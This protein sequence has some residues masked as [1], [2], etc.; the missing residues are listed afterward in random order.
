MK[1]NFKE[2]RSKSIVEFAENFKE[3]YYET[4]QQWSA[5]FG[6]ENIKIAVYE[7]DQLKDR[8]LFSDFFSILGLE[9]S[10]DYVL[11][12]KEYANLGLNKEAYLILKACPG[13]DFQMIE[14]LGIYPYKTVTSSLDLLSAS[15]KIKIIN[16]YQQINQKIA[17]EF[18][19]RKNGVLFLEPLPDNENNN[20]TLSSD[21]LIKSLIEI[22]LSKNDRIAEITNRERSL[23]TQFIMS[24]KKSNDNYNDHTAELKSTID[25]LKANI[26]ILEKKYAEELD[27]KTMLMSLDQQ[28]IISELSQDKK[29]I[30]KY[31]NELFELL[32]SKDG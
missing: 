24:K 4:I 29:N 11:P 5:L 22:L 15:E 8:S 1:S 18:L 6:K 21:D 17:K 13:I 9:I 32:N 27:Q 2:V 19:D 25:K 16:S 10:P 3:N 20:N 14:K 30:L 26:N 31:K 23:M 12:P 28:K 7:K